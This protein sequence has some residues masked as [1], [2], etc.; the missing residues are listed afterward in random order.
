M[1]HSL[2]NISERLELEIRYLLKN[3][4]AVQT[5]ESHN[6]STYPG[7]NKLGQRQR[8]FVLFLGVTLTVCIILYKSEVL[9]I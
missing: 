2:T 4:A 9:V 5:F 8:E 7:K 3:T 1:L 6:F